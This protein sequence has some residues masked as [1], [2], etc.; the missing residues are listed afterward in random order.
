MSSPIYIFANNIFRLVD[1]KNE[2]KKFVNKVKDLLNEIS[3]ETK[4]F[5]KP[6]RKT[7]TDSDIEKVEEMDI[8]I[9]AGKIN[10]DIRPTFLEKELK[11][12]EK[13][14]LVSIENKF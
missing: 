9:S 5:S 3:L 8:K 13:D 7:S 10:F 1:K 4:V 11:K 2:F 6:E 14:V 12:S